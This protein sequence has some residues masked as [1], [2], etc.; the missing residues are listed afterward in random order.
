MLPIPVFWGKQ[1]SK[2]ARHYEACNTNKWQ[3]DNVDVAV[4]CSNRQMLTVPYF[5]QVWKVGAPMQPYV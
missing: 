2:C 5:D 3:H 1:L 4:I